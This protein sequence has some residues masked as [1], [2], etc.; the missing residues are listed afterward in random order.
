[1]NMSHVRNQP[2][3]HT[4][5]ATLPAFRAF[6]THDLRRGLRAHVRKGDFACIPRLRR[7][8]SPQMVA[9]ECAKKQF[10]LRSAPSARTIS[11]DICAGTCANAISPAFRAF[12]T[13]DLRRGLCAQPFRLHFA[14]STRTISAEGCAGTAANA[15]SPAFRAFDACD[16]RRG[17]HSRLTP[18]V[19][20]SAFKE[21]L[22]LEIFILEISRSDF[23]LE[24][25]CDYHKWNLLWPS[26]VKSS[27]SIT[28][29]YCDLHASAS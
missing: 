20:P 16:L 13:H 6:N 24:I 12:N 23:H 1:M 28:E 9:P 3:K 21:T 17:L 26:Q 19:P 22:N 8:G 29:I 2:S 14:T 4:N 11:A 5:I 27:V 25:S 7:A 18:F 10:R 15:I